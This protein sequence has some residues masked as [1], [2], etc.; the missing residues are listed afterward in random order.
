[1][2]YALNVSPTATQQ[3]AAQPEP[4]RGFILAA[5]RRLAESPAA[6]GR[7]SSGVTSGQVAEFRFDHGGAGLWGT[8]TFLYGQDEQTLHVELITVE[9]GG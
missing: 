3:L 1:M 4:L 6:L 2:S 9:F 5:L 8:I 7:R